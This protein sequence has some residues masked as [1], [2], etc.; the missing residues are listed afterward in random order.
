MVERYSKRH[1]VAQVRSTNGLHGIFKF[2]EILG[3]TLY[4]AVKFDKAVPV[5][6]K[7]FFKLNLWV[8]LFSVI[9]W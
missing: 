9:A 4:A 1:L 7:Y 6:N 2:S 3:S 5:Y 8:S